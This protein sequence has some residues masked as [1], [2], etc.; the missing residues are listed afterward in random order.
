MELE[1]HL[2]RINHILI[3]DTEEKL[4]KAIKNYFSSKNMQKEYQDLN[5]IWTNKKK[6]KRRGDI[7]NGKRTRLAYISSVSKG[8]GPWCWSS[9][10]RSRLQL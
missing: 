8:F 6:K 3:L 1:K 4:L 10:Q 7:W 9:G 2:T 5:K